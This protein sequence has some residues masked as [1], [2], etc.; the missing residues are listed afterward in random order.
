MRY[1]VFKTGLWWRALALWLPCW[2]S[3]AET[4]VLQGDEDYPPI[5]YLGGGKVAGVL[6]AFSR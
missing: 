2:A 1:A 3:Q 5:S 6:P 4:L